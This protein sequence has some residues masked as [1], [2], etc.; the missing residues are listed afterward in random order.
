MFAKK[1]PLTTQQ[2][3]NQLVVKSSHHEDFVDS[4]WLL[5]CLKRVKN[6]P[7]HFKGLH[8]ASLST[9]IQSENVFVFTRLKKYQQ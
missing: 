6:G 9:I 4:F 7:D 8:V 3:I 5:R 1:M 2:K